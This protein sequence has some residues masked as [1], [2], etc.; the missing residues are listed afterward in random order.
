VLGGRRSLETDHIE[1]VLRAYG[2]PWEKK[3]IQP[4]EIETG[5]AP[6]NMT[7]V[8]QLASQLLCMDHYQLPPCTMPGMHQRTLPMPCSR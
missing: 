8:W 2:A 5:T 6:L 1:T 7:E 4:N 3:E